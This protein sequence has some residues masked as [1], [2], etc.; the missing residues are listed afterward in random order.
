MPGKIKLEYLKDEMKFSL[1]NPYSG[2]IQI[3]AW[4]G[5]GIDPT[6]S[7]SHKIILK[8]DQKSTGC[9]ISKPEIAK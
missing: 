1:V 6:P 2:G 4:V 3:V 9:G 5:G 7:R 8:L